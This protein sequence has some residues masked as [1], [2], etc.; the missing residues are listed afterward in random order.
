MVSELSLPA[1]RPWGI[2]VLEPTTKMT[3][4]LWKPTILGESRFIDQTRVTIRCATKG[5]TIRYTTDGTDPVAESKLYTEPLVLRESEFIK[6]RAF[7][8]GRGSEVSTARFVREESRRNILRNGGFEDGMTGWEL[9][10]RSDGRA[11]MKGAVMP[12]KDRKGKT[13]RIEVEKSSGTMRDL[14]LVQDFTARDGGYYDLRW[15]A[16]AEQPITIRVKLQEPSKPFRTLRAIGC[17]LDQQWREYS[18]RGYNTDR[19]RED[20]WSKSMNCRLQFDLGGISTGNVIWLDEV[21]LE[22]DWLE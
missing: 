17:T 9:V 1:I 21:Q 14:Q 10:D 13:M 3:G 7:E 15:W 5:A 18:L 19:K 20:S 16:R 11:A 4:H 6:A 2:I 12:R 22:E 8:A